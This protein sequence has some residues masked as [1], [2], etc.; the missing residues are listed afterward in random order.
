MSELDRLFDRIQQTIVG[1]LGL[2]GLAPEAID[3]ERPLFA[4]GLGLD[5]VDAL[6]LVVALEREFGVAI[7]TEALS[8]DDLATVEKIAG[9]IAR[10]TAGSERASA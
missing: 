7:P 1:S 9:L 4:E 8:G 6:E 3:P 2:D 5:S 10:L